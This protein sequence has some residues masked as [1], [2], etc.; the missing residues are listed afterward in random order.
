M[1][2]LSFIFGAL[3]IGIGYGE[4]IFITLIMY[5][6]TGILPLFIAFFLFEG[7][8]I[9]KRKFSISR[10]RSLFVNPGVR[11]YVFITI[12][13]PI[14]LNILDTLKFSNMDR[15]SKPGDVYF[16]EYIHRMVGLYSS[17]CWTRRFHGICRCFCV[18]VEKQQEVT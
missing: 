8:Q 10:F 13:I 14:L 7:K 16:A 5:L 12:I 18:R 17:A 4:P 6:L 11:V 3:S 1:M 2:I 9:F 15:L